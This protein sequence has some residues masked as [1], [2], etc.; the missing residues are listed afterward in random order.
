MFW[1]YK[2]E[3]SETIF[4]GAIGLRKPKRVAVLG[5]EVLGEIKP[6]FCDCKIKPHFG[7]HGD[8]RDVSQMVFGT[9]CRSHRNLY[10]LGCEVKRNSTHFVGALRAKFNRPCIGAIC[11]QR[12]NIHDIMRE[13]AV[14][15]YFG[16][17][18]HKRNEANILG[19]PLWR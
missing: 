6:I 10:V 16:V 18:C 15:K 13:T 5:Q 7:V 19:R 11:C 14:P 2:A 9:E 3:G 12:R 1:V 4:C 8:E 17:I